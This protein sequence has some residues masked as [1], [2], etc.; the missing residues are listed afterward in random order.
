MSG[1]TIIASIFALLNISVINLFFGYIDHNAKAP[2][3]TGSNNAAP[4]KD[5]AHPAEVGFN[6]LEIQ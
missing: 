4:A 1:K 6:S 3:A 5:A 2:S